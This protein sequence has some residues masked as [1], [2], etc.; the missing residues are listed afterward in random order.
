MAINIKENASA[1]IKAFLI[2]AVIATVIGTISTGLTM[3]DTSVIPEQLQGVVAMV[4]TIFN[5]PLWSFGVIFIRNIYGYFKKKLQADP[6]TH[7][8]I[9][10]NLSKLGETLAIYLPI[11][12]ILATMLP[13][14]YGVLIFGVIAV[15]DSIKNE[16]LQLQNIFK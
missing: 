5:V 15:I 13:E 3:I 10:Y 11:A 2:L 12:T 7:E 1:V 9:K 6:N 14:H 8:E 4:Q 16:I